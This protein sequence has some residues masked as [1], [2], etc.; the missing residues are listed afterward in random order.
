MTGAPADPRVRAALD[1]LAEAA[2]VPAE[3]QVV[4]FD[5]VYRRLSQVLAGPV[6]DAAD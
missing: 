5:D 1:R 6:A 3:Q 4:V 2:G